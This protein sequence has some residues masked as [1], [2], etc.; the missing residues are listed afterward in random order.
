[1]P[2]HSE[3]EFE[4]SVLQLLSV[5]VR[6][7]RIML[8]VPLCTMLAALGLSLIIPPTYTAVASFVPE[9]RSPDRLPSNLAGLAGQ[10]GISV[11]GNPGQS[12]RF[13]ADVAKSREILDRLLLTRYP[14]PRAS[15]TAGD[16]AA[17]FEILGTRGKNRA[18]SL[19]RGEKRLAKLIATSADAQTTVV[20]LAAEA[21]YPALAAMIA[22]D[23]LRYLNDFNTETR[24]SQARERRKFVERRVEQ[25]QADLLGAENTLKLFYQAN[26]SWQQ[27][28]GLVFMEGRLRRQ[29]EVQQELYLTLRR[30][31][32]TARID[33]VNDT[34]VI[35]TIDSA[36][37]PQRKS[38][39]R[40]L[41]WAVL[42]CLAG[43]IAALVW[44]F[45][46]EFTA[47][48]RAQNDPAYRDL[49]VALRQLGQR[50]VADAP[51]KNPTSTDM[52]R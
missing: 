3:A 4:V 22:N 5:L 36:V 34:P 50:T 41:L 24:Q 23:L 48:A 8:C 26:R 31:Y 10:L 32:E 49:A 18:D 30:E 19:E 51:I 38:A 6:R 11:G 9:T 47:R 52:V 13:Y 39:P 25:G 12:P 46:A 27:A 42:A 43:G 29:V 14:D 45:G 35:T 2:D 33:E 20:S 16:S 7:W 40:R 28:P 37:I 15:R 21:R 44:A 1:M 17:L